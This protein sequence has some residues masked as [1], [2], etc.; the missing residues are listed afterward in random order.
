MIQR[1]ERY[2]TDRDREIGRLRERELQLEARVAE[3]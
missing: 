2:V 3:L 1:L